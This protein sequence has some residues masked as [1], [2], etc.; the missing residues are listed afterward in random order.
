M[1][2]TTT[3]PGGAADVSPASRT[4][5]AA[6]ELNWASL[7][8]FLNA[9]ALGGQ[10]TTFQKFAIRKA[11]TTPVT[12]ATTDCAVGSKLSVPGAVAMNLPAG[13]N[14][15]VFFLFDDTGDAAANNITITPNG[16]NTIMG[17]A[18]YVINRDRGW[19]VIIFN[20]SDTDWKVVAQSQGLTNPM[21]TLGDTIYGGVS[22]VPTRLAGD[23]SNVRKFLRELSVTSTATAPVWDTLL[24]TD[25]PVATAAAYG[26]V[27]TYV[28]SQAAALNAVSSAGYTILDNDGYDCIAVSTGASQRTVTLPA[29]AN[30]IGRVLRIKK[31]DSGVGTI[32]ID[33]PGA[34]LIDGAAQNTLY[35]Q[36][37]YVVLEASSTG[38]NVIG[39]YD[40][41]TSTI[42]TATNAAASGTLLALTSIAIF[43]GR[44]TLSGFAVS[45]KNGASFSDSCQMVVGT[46]SAS[47]S[48]TTSGLS[49]T[50]FLANAATGTQSACSLPAI[51]VILTAA[52][53]Y[54]LNVAA[55]YSVA[56][57]QWRGTITAI[58]GV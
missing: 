19:V 36:Y 11:L 21:T 17:A 46:T 45:L 1:S 26:A 51:P 29:L 41:V 57:A 54:Y 20:S 5:P 39:A 16:A 49:E 25:L 28:P 34:E 58:R 23:T 50:Q 55:T 10:A 6:G 40:I 35:A 32:L 8:D 4:V 3:W 44:W 2:T 43:S 24:A 18:T 27:K 14:K 30:N 38:W 52:T 48:G 56:T 15:Q 42:S 22:G 53:T 7:S 33:T 37:S 47:T 31:T 9:L 12:V 13:A